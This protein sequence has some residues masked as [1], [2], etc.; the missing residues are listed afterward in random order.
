MTIPD[1]ALWVRGELLKRAWSQIELSRRSGISQ[2]HLAR[3]ISEERG[4]GEES[5]SGLAKAFG[6]P[7]ETL[8]RIAGLLPPIP[9]SNEIIKEVDG[10]LSSMPLEEQENV[11]EYTRM[12]KRISEERGN[13]E[14]KKTNHRRSSD[15]MS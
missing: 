3:F 10:L 5:I 2:S 14:N 11:R 7:P 13:Y 6:V 4:V 8:F 12:R 9:P 1:L 15:A